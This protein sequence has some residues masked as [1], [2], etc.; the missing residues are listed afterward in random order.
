MVIFF[1]YLFWFGVMPKFRSLGAD[2]AV[3]TMDIS[4]DDPQYGSEV[5]ARLAG[6]LRVPVLLQDAAACRNGPDWLS[7][8]TL[9]TDV[10]VS[11][12]PEL[13]RAA[14]LGVSGEFE[15]NL[16]HD[17]E[18]ALLAGTDSTDLVGR[19]ERDGWDRGE[20]ERYLSAREQPP[21]SAAQ[22]RFVAYASPQDA[23]G[24]GIL[25]VIDITAL[26]TGAIRAFADR[27]GSPQIYMA[28]SDLDP[29]DFY[30]SSC[31]RVLDDLPS[32]R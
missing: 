16:V 12:L 26:D 29:R 25:R 18:Q 9:N 24:H 3:I 13:V 23:L 5:N 11:T 8:I 28:G 14:E 20:V 32:L 10:V 1:G 27:A 7:D 17:A 31:D 22:E 2:G 4:F 19:L 15:S 6:S 21:S 30:P